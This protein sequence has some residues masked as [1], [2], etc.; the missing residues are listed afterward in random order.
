MKWVEVNRNHINTHQVQ[1]FFWSSGSLMIVWA[2]SGKSEMLPDPDKRFYHKLC[3]GLGL[4][5]YE[6]DNGEV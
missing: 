1:N 4:R 3:R 2:G 5:P 6:G